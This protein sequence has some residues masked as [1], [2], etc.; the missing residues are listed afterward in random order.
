[1]SRS[2]KLH[3][4]SSLPTSGVTSVSF[5]AWK[6]TLVA[7]LEQDTANFLFLPG[8]LYADWRARGKN[9]LRIPAINNAD[10]RRADILARLNRAN[11]ARDLHPD[12]PNNDPYDG[13]A[14]DAELAELLNTRNSQL[15]KFITHITISFYHF[16]SSYNGTLW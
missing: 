9:A 15:S 5:K 4:P 13:A 11:Q 10:T 7:Y 6:Q 8:G 2:L 1:M 12:H 3:P 14:R 16:Y